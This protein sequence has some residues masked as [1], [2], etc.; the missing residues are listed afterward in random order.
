MHL[1]WGPPF[2]EYYE[3]FSFV[4]FFAGLHYQKNLRFSFAQAPGLMMSGVSGVA[5]PTLP[6][7]VERKRTTVHYFPVKIRMRSD[8]FSCGGCDGVVEE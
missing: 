2:L 1:A 4:W 8:G 7:E 3:A 6:V 5:K